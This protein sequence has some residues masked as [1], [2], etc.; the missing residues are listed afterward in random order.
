[1]T[2]T[3]RSFSTLALAIGAALALAGCAGGGAGV[4]PSLPAPAPPTSSNPAPPATVY[5][6]PE[7]NQLVPTGALAAQQAG[8]TGAGVKVGI[9]DSGVDP[10]LADLDGQGKIAWFKSY[11][12]GGSQTPNDVYG[13]G[14][15][16]AQILGGVAV[17]GYAGGVAPGAAL[18][19]A[20]ICNASN[21]CDTTSPAFGDLIAQGV[22]I[23]NM[24]FGPNDQVTTANDGPA[25]SYF[26]NP[27]AQ[28]SNGL[29]VVAAGNQGE[30]Q[31]VSLAGLPYL[32]ATVLPNWLTVVNVNINSS[33]Q[34]AGLWNGATDPSNACGVAANW[35]L[36][37]PGEEDTLPVPGTAFAGG[38][39][40][41]GTS[42]STAVVTGVA[43][44]VSGAY[45]WMQGPQ[46]QDVLLTTATPLGNSPYPNATYG[47][48]MVNADKA[49]YGP[50]AFIFGNFNAAIGTSN[51]TFANAIGPDPLGS[52]DPVSS[53]NGLILSGTTGTLTLT[54]TDTYTGDTTINSA[55]LW[56]SGSVASPVIVNGGSFGGPGTVNGNVTVNGGSLISSGAVANAGLTITGN[57]TV[58]ASGTTAI[59]LGDPLTVDGSASLAGILEILA[60]PQNYT[61]SSLVTLINY[62]SETGT[63]ASQSYGAGVYYTVSNLSYGSTA[64]TADVTASNVAQTS[65]SLPGATALT[66]ATANGVQAS[67]QQINGWTAAQRA[68]NA[69]F[70]ANTGLFLAART[71]QQADASLASLSGQIYGTTRLLEVQQALD[72]DQT[73][74]A[75]MQALGTG[76]RPGVWLQATGGSGTSREAGTATAH[77][78]LGG[79]LAGVDLP[80]GHAL[81]IGAA[82]GRS[83]LDAT[84]DGLAGRVDGTL[85]T[86]AIYGR[87]G[88]A[89]GLD[90]TAVASR[91]RLAADVNRSVLLGTTVQPLAG[92]RTDTITQGAFSVGDAIG[93]WTP[94]ATLTALRLDQAAFTEAGAAGY[95]LTA[96]AQSHDATLGTLGLRY[97]RGFDWSLGEADVQ[98]WLAWQRTLSGTDLGFT[99][100]FAGTPT[101]LFTAQGQNLPRN[102]VAGG[103]EFSD[104]FNRTWSG[105]VD[106][107]L[108]HARGAFVSKLAT[109]GLEARF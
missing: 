45:P 56:L 72:T 73:L 65:A 35:C 68:A 74:A 103:L 108:T 8:Y 104:R 12:S 84:L 18:Y 102:T 76:T 96:P 52:N 9:L 86:V 38:G 43:A 36:S 22:H 83:H 37:A 15:T 53:N 92:R 107:G 97:G 98:G 100:A 106:L 59:A 21:Q 20:Q 80:L 23:F 30:P 47:W 7:Y 40:D 58:G 51:S 13:H 64:L 78:D 49:V 105:F 11:L 57:Y 6:Y 48:G 60:P 91:G 70:V 14:S 2:A 27:V 95:G 24:S 61:P 77:D 109:V 54:G 19:I 67:L 42:F 99:A 63:F 34:P 4:K 50:S 44:L 46:L 39:M 93:H 1:M 82:L 81:A 71:A 32:D 69:G 29:F 10:N 33:G 85:N 3:S 79:T 17:T 90:F 31:V 94:Y 5:S 25:L 28:Q 26:Y 16:V 55:N 66:R 88:R 89:Q 41:I 75:R 62:G 101:A 87:A